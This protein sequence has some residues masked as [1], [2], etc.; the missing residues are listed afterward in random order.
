M[1]SRAAAR[2]GRRPYELKLGIDTSVLMIIG[3]R[4][5]ER[6]ACGETST[7]NT[8]ES[9]DGSRDRRPMAR[10]QG[11]CVAYF[12]FNGAGLTLQSNTNPNLLS[13]ITSLTIPPTFITI[14]FLDSIWLGG[15]AVSLNRPTASAIV[16]IISDLL[17][18]LG[19]DG[20]SYIQHQPTFF[21]VDG[22]KL[23]FC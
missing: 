3:K 11:T 6:R 22:R 9:F 12:G 16:S 10:H 17:K 18:K 14:S 20:V 13:P 23:R 19:A 2:H 5:G 4:N 1:A 15:G 21:M 7:S 8:S